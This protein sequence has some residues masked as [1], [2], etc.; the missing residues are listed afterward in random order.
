MSYINLRFYWI[1]FI[2]VF[3]SYFNNSSLIAFQT[4][5]P[6]LP[7]PPPAP[8]G[9]GGGCPRQCRGP[10]GPAG[11]PAPHGGGRGFF[12]VPP[13]VPNIN[14]DHIG[15][16]YQLLC[17]C[18]IVYFVIGPICNACCDSYR[19]VV[20]EQ[21]QSSSLFSLVVFNSAQCVL[22]LPTASLQS[23]PT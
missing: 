16:L 6:P 20:A 13:P 19:Y 5:S 4:S 10:P 9:G 2:S 17:L 8:Y 12:T 11:G 23:P 15:K 21:N 22:L 14:E 3:F 18:L 7:S 1:Y